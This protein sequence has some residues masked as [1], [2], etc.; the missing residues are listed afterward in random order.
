MLELSVYGC[1][2]Y[3]VIGE[4]KRGVGGGGAWGCWSSTCELWCES[5]S[6]DE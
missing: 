3:L 1:E 5:E 2:R 4:K 6:E